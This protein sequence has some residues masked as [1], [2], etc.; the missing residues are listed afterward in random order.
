VTG[1]KGDAERAPR[2][3]IHTQLRYRPSG[4]TAWREGITENISRTGVLFRAEQ[5]VTV[6]T[7]VEMSFLLP[8]EVGGE[9]GAAVFCRG[10]IVRTVL[11]P[12]HDAAPALAARIL[13]Y[14]LQ[15]AE[16]SREA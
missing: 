15:R 14:A 1:I 3:P 13:E 6:N 11:P 9:E 8:V 10:M 5:I 2:F 4:E 16:P 12:A 7:P